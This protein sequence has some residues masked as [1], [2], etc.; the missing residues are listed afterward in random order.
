MIAA[1]LW[2]TISTPFVFASQQAHQKE[3]Q[4]QVGSSEDKNPFSTTTEEKNESSVSNLSEYLHDLNA[5]NQHFIVVTRIY[6]CH[7]ADLYYA[8]HPELLSP[9]PEV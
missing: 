4:K 5:S 1:L 2:L 8:F 9:P 7:T 6:K 3:I